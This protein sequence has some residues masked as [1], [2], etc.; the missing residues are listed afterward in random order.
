MIVQD[1]ISAELELLKADFARNWS[2]DGTP[3]KHFFC[4]ILLR[5]ENVELCR[6][7]VMN[8]SIPGSSRAWVVAQK[9]VDNF[10]GSIVENDYSTIVNAKNPTVEEVLTNPKLR[11]AIPVAIEINGKPYDHYSATT[12]TSPS[13]PTVS[14]RDGDQEVARLAIK[15]A[16]E[17]LPDRSRLEIKIDQDFLPAAVASLL[18]AAHLTM[19]KIC[20]YHYLNSAAGLDLAKIL[21]EFYEMNRDKPRRAQVK[22]VRGYFTK[23]QGMVAPL[24]T[25][26]PGILAGSIVDNRF[27]LPVSPSGRFLSL[28]IV[29]K[30]G[31]SLNLVVAPPDRADV[32]ATYHR[33]VRQFE[34]DP[35]RYHFADFVQAGGDNPAHWKVYQQDYVLQRI[36]V[37]KS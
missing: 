7:H 10:Y 20:G 31:D 33:I 17:G 23:F 6:G 29:I 18:K 15:V 30:A 34:K 16:S 13:H 19:F 8:Q 22:A 5:D 2:G 28:G 14:L 25:N 37:S 21:R 32:A 26:A 9:D 12:H 1:G 36:S 4:P 11:K 35:L 24:G 27:L 3:F